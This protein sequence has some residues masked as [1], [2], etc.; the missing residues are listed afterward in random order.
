MGP[1][2]PLVGDGSPAPE[3]ADANTYLRAATG[4]P[5]SAW[6]VARGGEWGGRRRDVARRWL[7]FLRRLVRGEVD[8]VVARERSAL[9]GT[10]REALAVRW[11][12]ALLL[13]EIHHRHNDR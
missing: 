5:Q 7:T 1:S 2:H 3:N 11:D 9:S 13:D 4:H 8:Q 6:S 12:Q 10:R